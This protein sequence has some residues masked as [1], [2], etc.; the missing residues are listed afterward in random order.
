MIAFNSI[1]AKTIFTLGITAFLLF[2]VF[3]LSHF[4]MP[5]TVDAD[6]HMVSTDCFLPGVATLCDM[7]AL[8]H[9]ATWKNAFSI[10]PLSLSTL[11]LIL[12]ILASLVFFVRLSRRESLIFQHTQELRLYDEARLLDVPLAVFQE[13]FSAGILNPKLF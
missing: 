8:G 12:C 7:S 1:F 3:G 11:L 5:M 6:G 2:G 10:L 4:A 9:L 13:L